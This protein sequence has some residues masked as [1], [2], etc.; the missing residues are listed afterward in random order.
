MTVKIPKHLVARQQN[1][2]EAEVPVVTLRDLAR[3][4]RAVAFLEQ[5][6]KLCRKFEIM[7]SGCGCCDSPFLSY[8]SWCKDDAEVEKTIGDHIKHLEEG[9]I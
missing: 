5:Y 6:E 8:F 7:V 3:R 9:E 2:A 1:D 4:R